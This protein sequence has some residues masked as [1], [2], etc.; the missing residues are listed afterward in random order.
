MSPRYLLDLRLLGMLAPS[1][2][3]VAERDRAV[4]LCTGIVAM[5]EDLEVGHRGRAARSAA[6]LMLETS[7]P[8]LDPELRGDLA[9]FCELAVVRGI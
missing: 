5:M 4:D 9:R 2:L 3:T 6:Q 1:S 8:E 7:V